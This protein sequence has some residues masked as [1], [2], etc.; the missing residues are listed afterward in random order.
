MPLDGA[1]DD[2]TPLE[3]DSEADADEDAPLSTFIRTLTL[4]PS[5]VNI[6]FDEDEAAA[7]NDDEATA[8]PLSALSANSSNPAMKQHSG[9]SSG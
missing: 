5:G 7:D 6:F 1:L 8:S 2:C 9:D 3:S 4:I